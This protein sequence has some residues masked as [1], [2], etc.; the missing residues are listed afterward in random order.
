MSREHEHCVMCA[1]F[2]T[3][4]YPQLAVQGQG[5]CEGFDR[6]ATW[7]DR[8][9]VLFNRARNPRIREA[10]AAKHADRGDDNNDNERATQ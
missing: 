1:R 3:K 5:H 6:V 2:T 9:C 4:G 7:N 10:F 8:R